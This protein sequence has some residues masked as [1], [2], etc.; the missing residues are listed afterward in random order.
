MMVSSD[1][2]TCFDERDAERETA[3]SKHERER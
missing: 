2:V 1:P 3:Q